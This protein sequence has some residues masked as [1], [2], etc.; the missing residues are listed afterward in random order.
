MYAVILAIR[1]CDENED[2]RENLS[3]AAHLIHGSSDGRFSVT[4]CTQHLTAEEVEGV[5]YNYLPYTS[6][7]SM[8][9]PSKLSDGW[10]T[11]ASGEEV[12][13]IS[14]PALGLWVDRKKF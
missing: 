2:L 8:Y 6:A 12:Y 10:N 9:D 1:L 7:M 13:Y 4:Y 3:A 14:N 11:L 5:G